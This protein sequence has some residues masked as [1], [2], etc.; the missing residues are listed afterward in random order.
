MREIIHATNQQRPFL[1]LGV[2]TI[3]LLRAER[4]LFVIHD[5]INTNMIAS[6]H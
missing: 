5:V 3:F 4:V 6:F 2:A 1:A